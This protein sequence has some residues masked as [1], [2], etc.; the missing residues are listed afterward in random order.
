M[1]NTLCMAGP[2][3]RTY[4]PSNICDPLKQIPRLAVWL[5]IFCA[6]EIELAVIMTSEAGVAE[7]YSFQLRQ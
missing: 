6:D 1:A 3:A 2:R 5:Q 4:L 7:A